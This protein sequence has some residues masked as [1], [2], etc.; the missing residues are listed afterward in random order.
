MIF[1]MKRYIVLK[2]L[3]ESR[4]FVIKIIICMVEV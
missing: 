3:F 1:R 4:I 2:Q